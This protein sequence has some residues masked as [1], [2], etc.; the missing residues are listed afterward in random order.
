MANPAG[1]KKIGLINKQEAPNIIAPIIEDILPEITQEM[2]EP[3]NS[4]I[5]AH[6]MSVHAPGNAQKNS[7]ITK[8]EIEAK[9]IGELTSHTHPG[10]GGGLTQQQIE[11][12]L[13]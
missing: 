11:G 9:L 7:D 2:F 5:Q 4:N 3:A 12:L 8:D 13:L 10:G 6:V 1:K